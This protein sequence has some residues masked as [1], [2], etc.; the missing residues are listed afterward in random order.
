MSHAKQECDPGEDALPSFIV[1]RL[2]LALLVIFGVTVLTFVAARLVP[3]DPAALYAGPRPNTAAIEAARAKLGLDRPLPLQFVSFVSD[4]AHGDLGISLKTHRPIMQDLIAFLPPT[5]E[6]VLVST[7]IALIGGVFLGLLAGVAAGSWFDHL[8]RVIALAGVAL[9]VFWLGLALQLVFFG[10][11]GWLPLS[12]RVSTDTAIL[13][14]I[15]R[16]TG[17]Y[18]IDAALTGNWEGWRDAAAHLIL[19]AVVLATYPLSVIFR[20]VRAAALET[21]AEPYILAARARG[22][23][24]VVLL[25][26]HVLKNALV[27]SLNVLGMAFVYSLTGAV[28]VEL[29]FAW[30]GLG[31]YITDAILN[32]DFPVVVAVT[33]LMSVVWSLINLATDIAQAWL[34]PRVK[35]R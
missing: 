26:K 6:L 13:N 24:R 1:R 25:L 2:L 22:V 27:P 20:L 5:L 7:C 32:V 31:R 35:L 28:L 8:S 29:I 4:L 33:L 18:L 23:S 10:W 11:L 9:P 3:A 30:P 12:G 14:P 15:Q 21:L 17:L 19:P 34:D 16:I